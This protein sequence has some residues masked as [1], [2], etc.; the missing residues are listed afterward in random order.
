MEDVLNFIINFAFI[1]L[2]Y[3]GANYIWNKYVKRK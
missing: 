2:L 1:F 3:K